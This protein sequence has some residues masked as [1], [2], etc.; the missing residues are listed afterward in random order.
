[1]AEVDGGIAELIGF[2]KDSRLAVRKGA[3]EAVLGLTA[4]SDGRALL[5][6]ARI[7]DELRRLL[8]VPT[9]GVA[10]LATKALVNLCED[11]V[12]IAQMTPLVST[13]ME[14]LR[15][16]DCTFKRE[17][18]MLLANLSQSPDVCERLLQLQSGGG[19]G[20]PMGLYFRVLIQWFL[21]P[22]GDGEDPFE[23]IAPLLQNLTQLPEAR[24]ILLEPERGILQPLL[25]QL[26]CP[27]VHRRRGIA[28]VLRNLCFETSET[29]VRYL[30]SPSVD[31]VTALLLPLAGPDRYRAE[32]KEGMP[33]VLFSGGGGRRGGRE[34]DPATRRCIVEA[35]VLL[36]STR[37]ARDFMRRCRCG[38]RG[39]SFS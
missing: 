37:P 38:C 36:A 30:L 26:G 5:Q 8:A 25:K 1:M 18:V 6:R 20:T 33:T 12:L 16:E 28:A 24:H 17:V 10:E 15:D 34:T 4:S 21:A 29:A 19:V 31:V 22:V 11:A 35:L 3:L 39:I 14:L 13:L 7:V 32:E 23:F 2:L 9:G 27:S